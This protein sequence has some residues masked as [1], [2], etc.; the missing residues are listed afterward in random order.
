MYP[1]S[2]IDFKQSR[3]SYYIRRFHKERLG[4]ISVSVDKTFENVSHLMPLMPLKDEKSNCDAKFE[5]QNSDLH[6]EI[7]L[8]LKALSTY[9][10]GSFF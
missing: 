5:T 9:F 7:T 1:L 8:G 3:F 6:V 2:Y 10:R 4:G